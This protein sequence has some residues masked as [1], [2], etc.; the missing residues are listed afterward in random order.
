MLNDKLPALLP[1]LHVGTVESWRVKRGIS[2]TQ[3]AREAGCSRETI[4]NV[5]LYGH[6]PKYEL[7][8]RIAAVLGVKV[9]DIHWGVPPKMKRRKR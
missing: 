1:V 9:M 2:A 4:V 8:Q 5:R 7:R 6:V 3:L